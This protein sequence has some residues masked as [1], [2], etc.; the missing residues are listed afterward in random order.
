MDALAYA[1]QAPSI[2]E[3]PSA[4]AGTEATAAVAARPEARE[5]TPTGGASQDN[6]ASPAARAAELVETASA[7]LPEPLPVGGANPEAGSPI[8]GDGGPTAN[9][10][11]SP[12][13]SG[14]RAASVAEGGATGAAKERV[15]A[16]E[17]V[18]DRRALARGIDA[19]IDLGDAGRVQVHAGQ[20][21]LRVD[22]RL[23]AD[24]AHTARTLADHARDLSL[25]LRTDT[26]DAR[27]TV[28]G[29]ST[30]ERASSD[31]RSQGRAGG[32][33]SSARREPDDRDRQRARDEA[34]APLNSSGSARAS[35]R[36][37]F[38]L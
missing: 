21:E 19:A 1:A 15:R 38:V 2:V 34:P 8:L 5:A 3:A 32:G 7:P 33:E 23:D 10:S 25:E 30:Y 18:A 6:G 22:I 11:R 29:P 4:S 31:E 14:G 12:A 9:V 26:R 17:G 28:T 27:V 35:R 13:R 16:A 20:K 37:R 36:A 24:V